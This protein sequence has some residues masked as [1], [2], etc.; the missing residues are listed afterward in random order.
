MS[1]KS[2]VKFTQQ[3]ITDAQMGSKIISLLFL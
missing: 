2:N 3:E 1:G